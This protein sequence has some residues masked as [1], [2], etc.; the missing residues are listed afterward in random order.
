M[1]IFAQVYFMQNSVAF[2]VFTHFYINYTYSAYWILHIG[3]GLFYEVSVILCLCH[4]PA[5][6]IL[7]IILS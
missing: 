5:T 4:Y 3:L 2:L 1:F 7:I 6:C